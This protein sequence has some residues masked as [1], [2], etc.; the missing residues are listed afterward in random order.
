MIDTARPT[1]WLVLAALLGGAALLGLAQS[2]M[3]RHRASLFEEARPLS[4]VPPIVRDG[5]LPFPNAPHFAHFINSEQLRGTGP[6]VSTP[7]LHNIEDEE[8][9]EELPAFPGCGRMA[10]A[11]RKHGMNGAALR[12]NVMDAHD[13]GHVFFRV[14][15]ERGLPLEPVVRAAV[16]LTRGGIGYK[17][18]ALD[19]PAASRLG[20]MHGT[21]VAFLGNL[22]AQER[23]LIPRENWKSWTPDWQTYQSVYC[24][25]NNDTKLFHLDQCFHGI[26]HVFHYSQFPSMY[27]VPALH[28]EYCLDAPL[29]SEVR[30]ISLALEAERLCLTHPSKLMSRACLWGIW[31]GVMEW[32][33]Q[34]MSAKGSM[35]HT[36]IPFSVNADGTNSGVAS[37]DLLYPCSEPQLVSPQPCFDLI[38][39]YLW[40]GDWR[41]VNASRAPGGFLSVCD[42][43]PTLKQRAGCIYAMS[44]YFY[45]VYDHVVLARSEADLS[46][47]PSRVWRSSLVA[48]D[49]SLGWDGMGGNYWNQTQ[50]SAPDGHLDVLFGTDF[51]TRE[52]TNKRYVPPTHTRTSLVSWCEHFVSEGAKAG[53]SLAEADWLRWKACVMG[54]FSWSARFAFEI[55]HETDEMKQRKCPELLEVSWLNKTMARASYELCLLASAPSPL[56]MEGVPLHEIRHPLDEHIWF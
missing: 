43:V 42:L 16:R 44:A 31:H 35:Q 22:V 10:E 39:A 25:A 12:V 48:Y 21:H 49:I 1:R 27:P 19:S 24:D 20:Y 7:L 11:V 13:L 45:P 47:A 37:T 56:K 53:A 38:A 17:K 26:G 3:S 15:L 5:A 41:A 28:P 34:N 4:F 52:H 55:Q 14:A 8:G 18:R 30:D 9:V 40:F 32:T 29:L 36:Y 6:I 2:P 23:A 33:Q 50:F 51:I 46:T 54:S